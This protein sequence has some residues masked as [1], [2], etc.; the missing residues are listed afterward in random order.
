M[1]KRQL[2]LGAGAGNSVGSRFEQVADMLEC[3]PDAADQVGICIDAAHLWAVGYDISNAKGVR[4]MFAELDRRV[5]LDRLKVVHLNDTVHG[6]GSHRDRHF[7][8]GQGKVGLVGF[9]E[10]VNYPGTEHLPGI[11][12]TPGQNVEFDKQ[13]LSVLRR[14]RET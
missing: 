9:R 5:G 8:I 11:I 1:Y 7:H 6:L 4:R 12:E 10:I 14:L 3:M 13:N 2:E